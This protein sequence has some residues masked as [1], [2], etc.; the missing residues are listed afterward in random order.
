MATDENN[1][2]VGEGDVRAQ[3]RQIFV[4]LGHILSAAGGA[5]DNLV[6]LT[7]Y[8][9][10]VDD[11]AKLQGVREEFLREPYPAVTGIEIV[12]LAD[13]RLLVEVDAIAVFRRP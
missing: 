1:K 7:Y 13:T 4:N 11:V 6:K 10:H 2:I 5:Y 12:R 9:Q 3:V 8:Y